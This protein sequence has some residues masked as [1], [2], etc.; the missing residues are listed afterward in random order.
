MSTRRSTFFYGLLIV[1]ASIMVGMV[2][3]SRLDLTPHSA[4][5]SLSLPAANNAPL[6]G[7]VDSGTFRT[8]AKAV[9]PA[10]VNI[11]TESRQR[12]E[13]LQDFFGGEN[14]FERFF[15]PPTPRSGEPESRILRS[16]GTGFIIDKSGLILTNN[17]VVEGTSVIKVSLYGEDPEQEHQARIV[18]RD[19][20]S[21]SA[22]IQLT[23][24]VDHELTEI[25]FGD[26]E[27]MQPGDWVMAIGNPF[28]LEHTVSVGV[29]SGTGR[30]LPTVDARAPKYIQ[31]DA[32]INPGNSGG[33]LLN[34][35]G[36]VIGINTAIISDA[37]EGNI[38]IGFATPINA[39]RDLLPQLQTGKVTRGRIGV[40]LT[41]VPR[42]AAATLGLKS[43]GG[44]IIAR[45]IPESA[46]AKAGIRAGDVVTTFNSRPVQRVEDLMQVVTATKPGTT[47]PARIIRDGQERTVNVTVDELDY[48][49]ELR[50]RAAGRPDRERPAPNPEP[51]KGFGIVLEEITPEVDRQLGLNGAK[52][53]LVY[54][55]EDGSP[56][57][58]AGL[59]RGDVITRV[60]GRTVTSAIEARDEM[61]KIPSGGTARVW[62]NR[63]GAERF[64]VITKE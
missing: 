14:P 38:G 37:R 54:R 25:R 50:Q 3:A 18:G 46:A 23:D 35:R 62:V 44:A 56:A 28:N 1:L 48:E 24:K 53:A 41:D 64:V 58:R 60:G 63:E 30:G 8:I 2:I 4:A 29:V 51:T 57:Q 34:L 45:V 11:R 47:V 17:H 49:A 15:G 9:S 6:N 43:R 42:N 52:G 36:E 32:A 20:L 12:A 21:D 59:R 13:D 39:I 16:A 55:V 31:T 5:Q 19:P 22:L 40:E 27:Q 7:P 26:S 33:P 61:Q 10:V